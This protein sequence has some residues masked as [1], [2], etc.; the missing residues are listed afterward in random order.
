MTRNLR[1]REGICASFTESCQKRV[2]ERVYH[3]VLRK[4]QITLQLVMKMI[5]GGHEVRFASMAREYILRLAV[6]RSVDEHFLSTGR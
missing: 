6:Q 5:E 4:L 3:A 1:D 2:A